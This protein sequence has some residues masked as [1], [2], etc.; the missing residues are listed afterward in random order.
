MDIPNP[1]PEEIRSVALKLFEALNATVIPVHR[2]K[3]PGI[4]GWQRVTQ[5][6]C[7]RREILDRYGDECPSI[8]IVT[9]DASHGLCSLDFDINEALEEFLRSNPTLRETLITRGARGGNVW[10]RVPAPCPK[11]TRFRRGGE[12]CGEVR[13][14]GGYTI[15]WGLH[16]TGKRY[17]M[18]EH[19]PLT[20]RFEELVWPDGFQ[21]GR[22]SKTKTNARQRTPTPP[23]PSSESSASLNFCASAPLHDS[24]AIHRTEPAQTP[25][26][27]S[28]SQSPHKLTPEQVL[29]HDRC[30][31][32][33]S[34]QLKAGK[35]PLSALYDRYIKRRYNARPH[36]RNAVVVEAVP[37]LYRAVAEEFI[38]ELLRHFWRC[39]HPLFR[40]TE[41]DHLREVE[42]M[43]AGV[44]TTF[45]NE[46]PG[47]ERELYLRQDPR[48][49]TTYRIC[50]DLAN[51]GAVEPQVFFMSAGDLALRLGVDPQQAHRVL[52]QLCELGI[53]QIE[54]RGTQRAK[55]VHGRATTY[56]WTLA[57]PQ[58]RVP[59]PTA[60]AHH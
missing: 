23:P 11:V 19:L 43:L 13:G 3:T 18:N 53:L 6:S 34:A 29:E 15:V 33:A 7:Q 39:H 25:G 8:A 48:I 22:K 41:A 42:A 50:R 58:P 14:N 20:M 52:R 54:T 49:Q 59:P 2:D 32:E 1:R 56:R 46:L 51:L 60:P 16:P 35:R 36:D 44:R 26:S 4:S 5:E 31:R 37:F 28:P 45:L 24:A 47:A 17:S 57:L 27:D 10:I 30:I 55:G 38:P 9:G 21:I 12:A 40:A